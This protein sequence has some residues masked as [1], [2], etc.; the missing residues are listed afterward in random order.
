MLPRGICY[1]N[2]PRLFFLCMASWPGISEGL[3]AHGIS[4]GWAIFLGLLIIAVAI[5][6]ISI[7]LIVKGVETLK[8]LSL[9]FLKKVATDCKDHHGGSQATGNNARGS[10]D[11]I[12]EITGKVGAVA[13]QAKDE[14]VRAAEEEAIEAATKNGAIKAK[15]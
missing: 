2:E 3:V 9:S 5:G 13:T 12:P 15:R 1:S 4:V 7:A 10:G 6:V 14:A 11:K 8:R